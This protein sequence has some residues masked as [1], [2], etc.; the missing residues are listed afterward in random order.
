MNQGKSPE[1]SRARHLHITVADP[2]SHVLGVVVYQSR[3]SAR[4]L[5][6]RFERFP[7][8]VT[9]TEESEGADEEKYVLKP[10]TRDQRTSRHVADHF[11]ALILPNTVLQCN[12]SLLRTLYPWVPYSC[13]EMPQDL[14]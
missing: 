1:D 9:V 14:C 4:L 11:F 8:H 10:E 5:G 6:L 2:E 7:V 12:K 13:I 3:S